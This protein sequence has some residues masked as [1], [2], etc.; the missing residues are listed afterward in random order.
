VRGSGMAVHKDGRVLMGSGGA[1]GSARSLELPGGKVEEGETSQDAP[2]GVEEELNLGV[3]V[4][5]WIADGADPGPRGAVRVELYHVNLDTGSLEMLDHAGRGVVG[6]PTV[7]ERLPCSPAFYLPLPGRSER[8]YCAGGTR[9]PARRGPR[10][11]SDA[12][13]LRRRGHERCHA[14]GRFTSSRHGRGRES[15]RQSPISSKNGR[16][17]RSDVA[18]RLR[19]RPA[20]FDDIGDWPGGFASRPMRLEVNV[21]RVTRLVGR[22]SKVSSVRAPGADRAAGLRVP[23]AQ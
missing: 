16:S 19:A 17:S 4:G 11:G 12:R 7:V 23:P 14:A 8:G 1:W 6:R 13:D 5:D 18:H 10:P 21:Q 2:Q 22:V 9:R 3:V 15:T 20:R